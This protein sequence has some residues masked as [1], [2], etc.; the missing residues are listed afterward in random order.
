LANY[1]YSLAVPDPAGMRGSDLAAGDALIMTLDQAR[2]PLLGWS[3]NAGG[4]FG[5]DD[6][7]GDHGGPFDTPASR[8]R[9][10]RCAELGR[11]LGLAPATVALAWVLARA[12]TF[13]SVGA[14]TAAHLDQAFQAPGVRLSPEDAA[15]LAAGD[16]AVPLSSA[17]G[18]KPEC[19]RWPGTSP[20]ATR[21]TGSV[22]ARPR[23]STT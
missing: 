14:G 11:K 6:G 20:T 18:G 2:L 22:R 9:L 12:D 19:W 8:A 1:H 5:R 15:W 3:A 7:R 23:S 4:Y 13:A 10:A 21:L 17:V 16:P